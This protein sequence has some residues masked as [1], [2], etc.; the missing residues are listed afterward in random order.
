VSAGASAPPLRGAPAIPGA[1]RRRIGRGVHGVLLEPVADG[2]WVVRG[3]VPRVMNVYLLEDGAG[4]T[5]FDAGIQDMARGIRSAA[6]TLG[7]LR[8][9]V[10]GHAHPD[11]RGAAPDLGVPVLCHREEVADAEGDGGVDAFDLSKLEIP[12]VRAAFPRLLD[13][14]DGGPVE[15][16][17]TL[18]E[19]DEVAGF[20][21][22][23]FPGHARGQIGL[24]RERDRLALTSDTFYTLNPQT[25]RPGLPRVAHDAFNLDT[26]QAEASMR[27]LAA[28]EPAAAWPGHA[29]PLV[30]DVGAQLEWALGL[31]LGAWR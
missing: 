6:E 9:V 7:G 19:G 29:D 23:H 10:L 17:G 16:S 20:E 11:H 28:L 21:V 30:G 25:S 13:L 14:W 24:W 4:V 22:V 5:V 27:K 1:G 31:E 3:G 12:P 18:A 26:P 2:V 8:R 15:I